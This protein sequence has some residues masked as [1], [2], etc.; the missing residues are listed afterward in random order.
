MTESP[1][2]SYRPMLYNY[3]FLGVAAPS[4]KSLRIRA[5]IRAQLRHS[6]APALYTRA[7]ADK[8]CGC[9]WKKYSRPRMDLCVID[10]ISCVQLNRNST[11]RR[12]ASRIWLPLRRSCLYISS[13]AECTM[14]RQ[15]FMQRSHVGAIL[16]HPDNKFGRLFHTALCVYTRKSVARHW[17]SLSRSLEQV[18]DI[19]RLSQLYSGSI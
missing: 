16:R 4:I 8:G 18:K 14:W 1:V 2:C 5:Q 15:W 3:I 6:T 12:T 10:F 17:C 13:S 7:T 9:W 11:D 19:R